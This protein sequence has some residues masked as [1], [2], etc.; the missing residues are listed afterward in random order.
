MPGSSGAPGP[1]GEDGETGPRGPRGETGAAVS[2][3]GQFFLTVMFSICKAAILAA[4]CIR[5]NGA[6]L[7]S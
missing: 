2:T 5:N 3:D 1:K 4:I 6:K 7:F